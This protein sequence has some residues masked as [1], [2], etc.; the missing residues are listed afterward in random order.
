M[1]IFLAYPFTQL[2]REDGLLEG[3]ATSF[4]NQAIDALTANGYSVFSAQK[5]EAFGLELM[6]PEV[7]TKLDF[8]EMQKAD[9]VVAFPGWFPISGGVHVELGWASALSRPLI[10]FLHKEQEY[11]PLVMGLGTVTQVKEVRF[12]NED[13]DRLVS[14]ITNEVE[15]YRKKLLTN[16]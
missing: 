10:L 9:L 8:I 5:R 11:S 4:L 15:A 2:L 3:K 16:A 13:L 1:R 14:M 12:G 6:T 7:A